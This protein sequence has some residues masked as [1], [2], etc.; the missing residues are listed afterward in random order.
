M[1]DIIAIRGIALT[2][3][4]D[5]GF[6]GMSIEISASKKDKLNFRQG[7]DPATN[8]CYGV[9]VAGLKSRNPA[10]RVGIGPETVGVEVAQKPYRYDRREVFS[11]VKEFDGVKF[12]DNHS[13]LETDQETGRRYIKDP[14]RPNED[15]IGIGHDPVGV[16][17]GDDEIDGI[18][19]NWHLPSPGT[20]KHQFCVDAATRFSSAMCFSQ[21]R[22][23]EGVKVE[24]GEPVLC[25]LQKPSLVALTGMEG[26]TTR[27]I[28]ESYAGEKPIMS[29]PAAAPTN[30][31]KVRFP[32]LANA[33]AKDNP[34]RGY[35]V[36]FGGSPLMAEKEIE[37]PGA[38]DKPAAPIDSAT[39]VRE[40]L[41]QIVMAWFDDPSLNDEQI[42]EK[43]KMLLQLRSG[44]PAGSE[45]METPDSETS[46]GGSGD[47]KEKGGNPFAKKDEKKT[48]EIASAQLEGKNIAI[49]CMG[50]LS[51]AGIPADADLVGLLCDTPQPQRAARVE[52]LKRLKGSAAPVS[53]TAAETVVVDAITPRAGALVDP[54]GGTVRAVDP[55][56]A[57]ESAAKGAA[58]PVVKEKTAD[59]I[60]HEFRNGV[61]R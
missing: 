48:A 8:I 12:Y 29:T 23:F 57:A 61:S 11:K 35:A 17:I 9:K 20:P 37:I 49:E 39:A 4:G 5:D 52:T 45:P 19:V 10:Y 26:G 33:I 38:A 46:G 34:I 47:G 7:Y 44:K 24:N 59:E 51:A 21:E 3:T 60:L 41:K 6:D 40:S 18:Y 54:A 32:A 42:M 27:N 28:F 13:K 55:A 2:D 50:L 14:V 15:F 43:M 1:A 53:G 25:D 58:A 56:V 31:R 36:E 30:K 16:D 22:G